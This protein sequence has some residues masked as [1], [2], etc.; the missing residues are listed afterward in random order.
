MAVHGRQR[1]RLTVK[2]HPAETRQVAK[3]VTIHTATIP[4]VTGNP[5]CARLLPVDVE[6]LG[7]SLDTVRVPQEDVRLGMIVVDAEILAVVQGVVV[8]GLIYGVVLLEAAEIKDHAKP[9]LVGVVPHGTRTRTAVLHGLPMRL[10]LA[11]EVLMPANR[12]SVT[13]RVMGATTLRRPVRGR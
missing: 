12:R 11:E 2:I 5:L 4:H 8:H 7:H 10:L 6:E 1:K 13:L 3:A 9:P